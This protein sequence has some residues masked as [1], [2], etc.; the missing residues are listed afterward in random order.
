M[1]A[2]IIAKKFHFENAD[3]SNNARFARHNPYNPGRQTRA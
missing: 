2:I 3:A 1:L